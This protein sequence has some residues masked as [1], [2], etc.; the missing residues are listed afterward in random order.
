MAGGGN[1]TAPPP[2]PH[3][4]DLLLLESVRV[5]GRVALLVQI[6]PHELLDGQLAGGRVLELVQ[7]E[8]QRGTRRRNREVVLFGSNHVP[9]NEAS[10]V[11]TRDFKLLPFSQRALAHFHHA[12]DFFHRATEVV[13]ASGDEESWKQEEEKHWWDL[14]QD[15][16]QPLI[17]SVWTLCTE[18]NLELNL[19]KYTENPPSH[20]W[21]KM[22]ATSSHYPTSSS[23][24]QLF[25]EQSL[26]LPL[27]TEL[28]VGLWWSCFSSWSCRSDRLL[29]RGRFTCSHR[30]QWAGLTEPE[31]AAV[32]V[33]EFQLHQGPST[34]RLL[35]L[36]LL[37]WKVSRVRIAPDSTLNF[38]C[39]RTMHMK[40]EAGNRNKSPGT[41]ATDIWN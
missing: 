3:L 2:R 7:S 8:G 32:G 23:T 21:I 15:N 36:S 30:A 31:S 4:L 26:T 5:A 1:Y 22:D 24:E 19:Y 28:L 37:R 12:D 10:T 40:R 6:H 20:L 9:P 34:G 41:R 13:H 27:W 35:I 25:L 17:T 16:S 11:S 29:L 39:S 14:T 33:D 18:P 38:L